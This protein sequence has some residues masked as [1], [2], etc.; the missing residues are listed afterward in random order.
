M[1]NE[2]HVTLLKQGVTAWN[3]W[4]S[5]NPTVRPDLHGATLSG[6][7]LHGVD[8]TSATLRRASLS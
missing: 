1:A 8:F 6:A 3:A 4:R 5:E 2:E 7:N